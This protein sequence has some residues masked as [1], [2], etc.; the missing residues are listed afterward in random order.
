MVWLYLPMY[1][2]ISHFG[3]KTF[4]LFMGKNYVLFSWKTYTFLSG[5]LLWHKKFVLKFSWSQFLTHL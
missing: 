3:A 1:K 2:S 4:L 5:M